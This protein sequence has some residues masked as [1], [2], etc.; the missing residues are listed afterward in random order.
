M[1]AS[2]SSKAVAQYM[3][4]A[5]ST[6]HFAY[7]SV[8]VLYEPVGCDVRVLAVLSVGPAWRELGVTLA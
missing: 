5:G 8:I 1:N 3:K 2:L 6:T 7:T 4:C